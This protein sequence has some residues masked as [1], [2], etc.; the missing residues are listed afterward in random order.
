[1]VADSNGFWEH[2]PIIDLAIDA[3]NWADIAM[4]ALDG[5]GNALSPW[6]G[7]TLT[8]IAMSSP[9]PGSTPI[10]TSSTT[11]NSKRPTLTGTAAPNAI[12]GIA[13]VGGNPYYGFATADANGNWSLV[14][15]QD[16]ILDANNQ[17]SIGIA[18]FNAASQQTSVWGSATLSITGTGKTITLSGAVVLTPTHP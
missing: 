2:I 8:V 7:V 9:A 4:M 14:P 17:V 18:E 3:N 15:N 12:V 1:M 13:H 5:A 10:L 6:G 16:L 11:V